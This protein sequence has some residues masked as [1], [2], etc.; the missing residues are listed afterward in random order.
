MNR[1]IKFRAWLASE[2]SMV[3]PFV[4]INSENLPNYYGSTAPRHPLMQYTG[5]KDIDGHDIYEGDIVKATPFR[6]SDFDAWVGFVEFDPYTLR[7][8]ADGES[9][10]DYESGELE[11]IGNIYENPEILEET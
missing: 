3:T 6:P 8:R 5:L 4:E 2:N 11:I 9:L 10:G 1:E 7:Y